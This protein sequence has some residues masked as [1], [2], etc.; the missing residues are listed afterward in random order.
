MGIIICSARPTPGTYILVT[1]RGL[2]VRSDQEMFR[3]AAWQGTAR[4]LGRLQ[5][6]V[7]RN[8]ECVLGF[9]ELPEVMCA[10]HQ[11]LRDQTALDHLLYVYR[12]RGVFIRREFYAVPALRK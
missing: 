7:T 3:A 2:Y 4:E 11:M 6:A 1:G 8:C 5:N 12:M 9:D 10:A